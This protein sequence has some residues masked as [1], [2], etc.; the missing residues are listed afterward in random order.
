[1]AIKIILLVV[2][3]LAI[4]ADAW[5]TYRALK[6]GRT[7]GN[8]FRNFPI[9]VFGLTGGTYG[10]AVVMT[11]TLWI[12]DYKYPLT[13][14]LIVSLISVILIFLFIASLNYKKD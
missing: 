10:V 6:T 4:F 12:I 13:P 3:S 2:A 9:K 8:N 5:T 1:M 14:T 7:E 11:A